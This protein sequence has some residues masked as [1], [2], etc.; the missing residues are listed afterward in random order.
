MK[1]CCFSVYSSNVCHEL[2][3]A[4]PLLTLL[5]PWEAVLP[6]CSNAGMVVCW[7]FRSHVCESAVWSLPSA[8]CSSLGCDRDPF[9]NKPGLRS[10]NE[11][12]G[13]HQRDMTASLSLS[14]NPLG[15]T[16]LRVHTCKR[17]TE[18]E[19]AK[20]Q[21]VPWLNDSRWPG[22][23]TTVKDDQSK[24]PPSHGQSLILVQEYSG[25]FLHC[26]RRGNLVLGCDLS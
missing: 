12:G 19:W 6:A 14:I 9:Q 26:L 16:S 11:A 3:S 1:C 21:A 7:F 5:W 15:F 10:E 24:H 4:A 23:R 18:R 20:M 25:S 8:G 13:K 17:E 22:T 2:A